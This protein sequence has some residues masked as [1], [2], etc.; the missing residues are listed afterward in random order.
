MNALPKIKISTIA[1]CWACLA[2]LVLPVCNAPAQDQGRVRVKT[3]RPQVGADLF[4]SSEQPANVEAYYQ[5]S[6]FS[7]S[8]G[9]VKDIKKN[10]GDFVTV[11]E[12]LVE[13]ESSAH[14]AAKITIA[15]P[16]DGVIASRP[17]DPGSFV[18][19]PAVVPGVPALLSLERNDIVTISSKIPESF[20]GLLGPDTEAEVRMD[21]MPGKVLR[22]KLARI[23]PSLDL[24][25]RTQRVEVDF[26]NRS[27]SEFDAFVLDAEAKQKTDL[28][29]LSLP[30]FPVGVEPGK[31]A[32]FIPGMYG[33]MKVI[34]KSF[35]NMPLVP[36]SS[37]VRFG[38]MP[39]LFQVE[40]GLARR[41]PII[42]DFDD[43]S[44]ARVR[45]SDGSDLSVEDEIIASNQGELDDGTPIDPVLTK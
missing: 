8:A 21:A 27:Q 12:I 39:Y 42:I 31:A 34:F 38:G 40:N 10:L 4:I 1:I 43:G 28:K 41:N 11:G 7:P 18:G 32:G 17:L 36:T 19:N 26:Y 33:K 2:A 30:I 6:L 23:A 3:I 20:I 5:V 14:P 44:F 25:D 35:R 13:M 15:A 37:I 16:F 45:W 9:T 24:L 22:G 29:S